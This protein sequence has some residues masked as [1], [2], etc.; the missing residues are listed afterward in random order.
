M[1]AF[2]R[3]KVIEQAR[4][5]YGFNLSQDTARQLEDRTFEVAL[6]PAMEKVKAMMKFLVALPGMPTLYDGDDKGATGYDTETKN[7]YLQGR[8]RVHNEWVDEGSPRKKEFMTKFYKE[9]NDINYK[10]CSCWE[11]YYNS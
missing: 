2:T 8:Q 1:I 7:M 6:T 4:Y 10:W 3:E 9:M 11:C 5:K